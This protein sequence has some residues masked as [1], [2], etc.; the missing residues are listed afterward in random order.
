MPKANKTIKAKK[1]TLKK[2]EVVKTV[3]TK[4]TA[5]QPKAIAQGVVR[6]AIID[7]YDGTSPVT[8]QRKSSTRINFSMFGSKMNAVMTARDDAAVTGLRKQYGKS[9]FERGNLDAGIIR[10]LGERGYLEHVEGHE[11]SPTTKF[12]L[13]TKALL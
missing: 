9:V 3:A 12:R 2:Q 11:Q 13:T 8:I 1:L 6:H 7:T 10:R 4:V 5:K